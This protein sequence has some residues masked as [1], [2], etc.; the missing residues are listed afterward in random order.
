[1]GAGEYDW[2]AKSRHD[3]PRGE[4]YSQLFAGIAGRVC[5]VHHAPRDAVRDGR[6]DVEEEEE[7]RP[8]FATKQK[9][10]GK[11]HEG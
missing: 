11:Q 7:E 1:M 10:T 6:Q 4:E 3:D 5:I 2:E 9:H 8:V